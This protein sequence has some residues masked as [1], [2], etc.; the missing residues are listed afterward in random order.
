MPRSGLGSRKA[1]CLC[2]RQ[3]FLRLY[4][5]V[6]VNEYSFLCADPAQLFHEI[7]HFRAADLNEFALIVFEKGQA[8]SSRRN[9]RKLAS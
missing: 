7:W 6:M 8:A 9:A 1:P 3:N 4:F 2:E 5:C